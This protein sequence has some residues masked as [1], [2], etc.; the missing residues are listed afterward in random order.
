MPIS[1]NFADV[2]KIAESGCKPLVDSH[3]TVNY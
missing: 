1:S 2:N 3:S